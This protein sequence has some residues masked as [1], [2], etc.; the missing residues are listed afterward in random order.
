MTAE[1][2]RLSN[3]VAI[4]IESF[5]S[6]KLKESKPQIVEFTASS[7]QA[8]L[9]V[10]KWLAKQKAAGWSI[11]ANIETKRAGDYAMTNGDKKIFVSFVDPG[12]ISAEITIKTEE[13]FKLEFKK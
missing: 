10:T 5:E 6:P 2:D 13:G 4:A 9:I 8:Q 3:P 7:G 1:Q 12:L 11:V